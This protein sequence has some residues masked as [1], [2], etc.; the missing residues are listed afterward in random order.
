MQAPTKYELVINL[1]TGPGGAFGRGFAG[2]HF[3]GTRG[4]FGHERRFGRRGY[5]SYDYGCG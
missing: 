1:K 4:H 3:A 2:Q 5:G